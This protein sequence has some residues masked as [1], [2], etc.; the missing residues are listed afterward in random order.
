M[1]KG[2]RYSE[3]NALSR[4]MQ[5]ANPF[6]ASKRSVFDKT[7]DILQSHVYMKST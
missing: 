4:K 5:T 2:I 7:G 3:D 1:G 6:K